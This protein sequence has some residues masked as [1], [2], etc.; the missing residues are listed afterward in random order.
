[1][2][3]RLP[4]NSELGE[5]HHDPAAS[6]LKSSNQWSQV[7]LVVSTSLQS[8][9]VAHGLGKHYYDLSEKSTDAVSLYSISAGFAS[10]LATSWSKTSFAT[11]LLRITS[12]GT[13]M[14]VWLIILTVNLVMA[15]NGTVQ[16]VQCWPVRKQWNT[17]MEGTCLP[18]IVV[19]NYNTFVAGGSVRGELRD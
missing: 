17:G 10:I 14:C 18:H 5:Y 16:W 4:P 11:S 2:V 3:G 15:A 12:G 7:S 19:Q 9:G 13:R 1:M 6:K 8:V